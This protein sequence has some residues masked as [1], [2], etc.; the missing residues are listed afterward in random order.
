VRE[1]S[2]TDAELIHRVI[3]KNDIVLA[4]MSGLMGNDPKTLKRF[5]GEWGDNRVFRNQRVAGRQRRW[6][7]VG[8]AVA[9]PSA[10][11]GN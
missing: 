2:K 4:D 1:L 9:V 6:R 11:T 10:R 8:N 7:N 3:E 5:F